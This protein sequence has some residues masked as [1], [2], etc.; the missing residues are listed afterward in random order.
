MG[1]QAS[2]M[3][4]RRP[5]AHGAP[6]ALNMRRVKRGK[7]AALLKERAGDGESARRMEDVQG[8]R[9]RTIGSA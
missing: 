8:S 2:V 1:A 3:K 6:K 4:D 9:R 7:A 5:S